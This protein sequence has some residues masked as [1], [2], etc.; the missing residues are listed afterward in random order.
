VTLATVRHTMITHLPEGR[1]DIL[2]I[3]HTLGDGDLRATQIYTHVTTSH[4]PETYHRYHHFRRYT[5]C[6]SPHLSLGR[7]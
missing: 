2:G 7:K 4:L 5:V 1:A 3:S 6:P